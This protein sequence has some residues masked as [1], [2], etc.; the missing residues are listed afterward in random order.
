MGVC[1]RKI[2]RVYFQMK[3]LIKKMSDNK[4]DMLL[5]RLVH[6]SVSYGLI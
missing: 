4:N 6:D 2:G 3:I 5:M 1:L